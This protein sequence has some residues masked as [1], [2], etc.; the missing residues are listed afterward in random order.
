MQKFW[1]AVI[2][3]VIQDNK[4]WGFAVMR[5]TFSK[6]EGIFYDSGIALLGQNLV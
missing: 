6:L 2:S 5:A 1:F 3:P 4:Q